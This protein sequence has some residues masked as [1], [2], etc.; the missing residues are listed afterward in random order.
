L[1]SGDQG[2]SDVCGILINAQTYGDCGFCAALEAT[3]SAIETSA[4]YA[5]TQ[6]V[7][8]QVGVISP[9]TATGDI[10][11]GFVAVAEVGAFQHAFYAGILPGATWTNILTA[12]VAGYANGGFNVRRGAAANDASQ[13][14]HRGT[15]ALLLDVV[16][17]GQ[18]QFATSNTIRAAFTAEGNFAPALGQTINLGDPSARWAAAY[19]T[20][21]NTTGDVTH[22]NLPTSDPRISGRLW[23]DASNVVRVSP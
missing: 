17:A 16:E 6:S 20:A 18:I 23:R 14:I 8:T 11:Y 10:G 7:Q 19:L 3:T 9:N 5:I 2:R 15:G 12:Q 1:P 22:A 21:M 4:P 13:I